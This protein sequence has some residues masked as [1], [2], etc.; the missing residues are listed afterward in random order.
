MFALLGVLGG[1]GHG[2][3]SSGHHAG[4]AGHLASGHD[5]GGHVGASHT[6][7]AH[8]GTA[9]AGAVHAGT[10][11]GHAAAH[12]HAHT[13][14]S[15][16]QTPSEANAGGAWWSSIG[17]WTLSWLSPIAIAAAAL[18]FGGV[19]L[20]AERAIGPFSLVI[21]VLAGLLGAFLVR[22]LM[23]AFVRSETPPLALTAEGALATVNAT[24]RPGNPGEVIYTL[25]GLTRSSPARSLDGG[26][27]VRGTNVAIV[28]TEGGFAWVA[29]IDFPEGTEELAGSGSEFENAD[30][31]S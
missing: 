11:H 1:A 8:A 7:G 24:I 27:L 2:H 12:V 14:S 9:P 28:K 29:P 15:Q 17:G 26:T 18:W 30:T 31:K 13:Q 21:A 6:A 25:E 5:G 22:S 16:G 23:A 19:G 3:V 10:A 4:T 20:L